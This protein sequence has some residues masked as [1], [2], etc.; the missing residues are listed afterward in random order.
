MELPCTKHVLA[1]YRGVCP[2]CLQNFP[3]RVLETSRLYKYDEGLRNDPV[4]FQRVYEE[5]KIEAALIIVVSLEP[6]A[7]VGL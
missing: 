1:Q 6:T 5:L 2:Q 4:E 3:R 7:H